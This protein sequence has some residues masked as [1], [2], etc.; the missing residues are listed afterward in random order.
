MSNVYV[1]IDHAFPGVRELLVKAGVLFSVK[2]ELLYVSRIPNFHVRNLF[3][4]TVQYTCRYVMNSS[5]SYFL[6]LLL[7]LSVGLHRCI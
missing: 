1:F 2:R 5:N 4:Y 6:L 3:L 7:S